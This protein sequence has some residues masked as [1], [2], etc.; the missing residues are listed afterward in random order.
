MRRLIATL[1]LARIRNSH[2]LMDSGI[3]K[4]LCEKAVFNPVSALEFVTPDESRR[5]AY[6]EVSRLPTSQRSR[7]GTLLQG[8]EDNTNLTAGRVEGQLSA[9]G[10]PAMEPCGPTVRDRLTLVAVVC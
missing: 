3:S 10:R 7:H 4:S 8:D 2:R 9:G 5:V 1:L 6:V